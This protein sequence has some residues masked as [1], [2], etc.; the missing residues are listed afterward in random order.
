MLETEDLA[1]IGNP[2]LKISKATTCKSTRAS[3]H[4]VSHH[5]GL[6]G[7][8]CVMIPDSVSWAR[9]TSRVSPNHPPNSVQQIQAKAN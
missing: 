6:I 1:G 3:W 2:R 8:V 5:D 7:F 9:T 4:S